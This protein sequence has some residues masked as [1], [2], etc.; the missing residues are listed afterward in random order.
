MRPT[1]CAKALLAASLVACAA[2]S[3]L[4][5]RPAMATDLRLAAQTHPIPEPTRPPKERY[6]ALTCHDWQRWDRLGRLIYVRALVEGLEL[7]YDTLLTLANRSPQA[8][9]DALIASAEAVRG[10]LVTEHR[11]G[12]YEIEVAAF[13]GRP[14]RAKTPLPQAFAEA[15]RALRAR[16]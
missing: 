16:R 6:Q 3:T 12:T 2:T 1:A 4:P 10:V 11:V 9:G 14:E 8:E 15:T 13:C 7:Y 5:Q